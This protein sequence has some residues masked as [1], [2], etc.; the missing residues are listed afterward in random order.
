[1]KNKRDRYPLILDYA[2]GILMITILTLATFLMPQAYG[3]L[4]D[5]QD[6]NQV[7]AVERESFSFENLID[8]T[9]YERIQQMMEKLS[10][11][12]RLRRTLY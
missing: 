2:I 11:K 12:T 6:L 1:M 5:K 9:V 3:A 7:H 10:G 8:M 4:M